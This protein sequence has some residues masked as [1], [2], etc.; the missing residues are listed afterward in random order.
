[1]FAKP[2]A[3]VLDANILVRAVFGSR[4][5]QLIGSYEESTAF[6]TPAICFDEARRNLPAIAMK[7]KGDPEDKLLVLSQLSEMIEVIDSSHYDPYA[8]AAR[9]RIA[10]R[11]I[12]DWPIVATALLLNCPIWTEDFDFFGCGIATWTTTT[13]ELYLRD[14]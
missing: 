7:R 4:V 5:R 10:S 9:S 13:V 1:M 8:T 14:S 3:L 12:E 2:K 6:C 11:D